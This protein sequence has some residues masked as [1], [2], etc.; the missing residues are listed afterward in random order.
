VANILAGKQKTLYLGN[1]DARRDWGYAPEYVEGMWKIMQHPKPG[2][3]VLGTG[4]SHSVK[5]FVEL[6]FRYAGINIRW[7][8]SNSAIKGMVANVGS[9]LR[10]D[11]VVVE[12]DQR[13]FR[14]TEV[15]NLIADTAKA[16]K[17]LNWRPK[18]TFGELVKIMVDADMRS[19]GLDPVGEGDE[20]LMRKFP[21][22]WWKGD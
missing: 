11:H 7:K 18:I 2:D 10:K 19:I 17:E 12:I 8:G 15:E 3:F 6:A 16:K 20:I 21:K 9:P 22:K 5:E 13:Y 1:L 4:E 14:P